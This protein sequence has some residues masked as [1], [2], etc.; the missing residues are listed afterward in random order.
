MLILNALLPQDPENY[1]KTIK[2]ADGK[3]TA[4]DKASAQPFNAHGEEILDGTDLYL[5]PGLIDIHTHGC[6]G[7]DFCD[8]TQESLEAI[9]NYQLQQGI[10]GFCPTSMTL[11]EARLTEIFANAALFKER[12]ER[13]EVGGAKL[14]G[15]NMEG[16]FL[17]PAKLGAQ[18][19]EFLHLPDVAMFRRLQKAANGLIKLVTIAPELP[20][21]LEFIQEL[22]DE[23]IISLGHSNATYAETK[24]A[25]NL[26]ASHVTHTYNA[27][28]PLHHRE[29][30]LIGAMLEQQHASAELIADGIHLH[31]A[32]VQFTVNYLQQQKRHIGPVLISDSM[33]ATGMPDGAYMLGGLAVTKQGRKATLTGTDTIAGSAS[34]LMDCLKWSH[35]NTVLPFTKLLE[36][37]TLAPA[38]RLGLTSIGS[39]ALGQTADLLLADKEL[40]IKYVLQNGKIVYA[41]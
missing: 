32:I 36:C 41:Y 25:F 29:P 31:P 24:Q 2:I 14:L 5:L 15:I 39:I 22:K 16:P 4:I 1:T 28:P 33:E 34:N 40:N 9:A 38:R 21:A 37:C 17:A 7:H 11:S 18:N 26:G 3:I 35:A 23:V 8:A 13:G 27:M 6:A 20:G 12:Q 19:P 30:G 10:T